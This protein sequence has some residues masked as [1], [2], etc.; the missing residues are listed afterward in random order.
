MCHTVR[1]ASI[2]AF[3]LIG[4]LFAGCFLPDRKEGGGSRTPVTITS[5]SPASG[6]RTGGT[7]V[8]LEGTGFGSQPF[9]TLGSRVV[10]QFV[11]VNGD[12]IEFLSPP[13]LVGRASLTVTNASGGRATI[14]DAFFYTP[15]PAVAYERRFFADSPDEAGANAVLVTAT[16][17]TI[18]Q[19]DVDVP[20]ADSGAI[21]GRITDASGTP[22]A[23]HDV[24]A[25]SVTAGTT[26]ATLTDVDGRYRIDGLVAGQ[27]T[28]RTN[29][30]ADSDFADLAWPDE[31]NSLD[32]DP[33]DVLAGSATTG[34][35]LALDVGGSIHG[36]VEGA[37]TPI[38]GA[39]VYASPVVSNPLQF[40]YAV[41][42]ATGAWTIPGLA[43]GDYRLVASAFGSGRVTEHWPDALS[44]AQASPVTVTAGGDA[45]AD[46]DLD[47]GGML[48]GEILESP[49]LGPIQGTIVI[50][51]GID[52]G[53]THATATAG[54]GSWRLG[55]LP[56]GDYRVEAPELAQWFSAS[57]TSAGAIVLGVV[58]GDETANVS[59]VGRI[60]TVPCGDPAGTGSVS[61]TVTDRD[62]NPLNRVS[63]QLLPTSSGDIAFAIT[64]GDGG[65]LADCVEPGLYT[66]R[67]VPANDDLLLVEAATGVDV[68]TDLVPGIDAEL[69]PGAT[70]S[71]TVRDAQTNAP[72]ASVPVR[73]RNP[74][75]GA[76]RIVQTGGDGRWTAD[77]TSAGGIGA[78][79]WR[80][81][82]LAHVQSEHSPY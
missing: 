72:L 10:E 15:L 45:I 3:L 71:G 11:L 76:T 7:V 40:S 50:A 79:T 43:P 68:D 67:V 52:S 30:D 4:S 54:D 56:P 34:I 8:R 46:F 61:G 55:E 44:S 73:V 81:E 38:E 23:E 33:I 32:A 2:T 42:D 82:A 58:A 65:W 47:E 14:V 25:V 41:T 5:V 24:L 62:G 36:V 66:V 37:G 77:R 22:L 21:E 29:E 49:L 60:G 70:L 31:P 1:T 35:D 12:A 74:G 57:V 16:A 80:V 75:T 39:I 51:H 6:P 27:W 69:P 63:V 17:Q 13:D 28:I 48:S 18:A 78:G 9:V 26:I 59:F 64:G 20:R 53:L 19:L